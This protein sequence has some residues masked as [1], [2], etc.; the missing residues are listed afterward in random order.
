MNG[1][2]FGSIFQG[3]TG[4]KIEHGYSNVSWVRSEKLVQSDE[5]DRLFFPYNYN[6]LDVSMIVVSIDQFPFDGARLKQI[7][8]IRQN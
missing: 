5:N 3:A 4:Q 8:D 1:R 2:Q 7:K 6:Y